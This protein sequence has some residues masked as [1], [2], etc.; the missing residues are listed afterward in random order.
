MSS[1][2]SIITQIN[3]LIMK[4]NAKTGRRDSDLTTSYEALLSGYSVDGTFEPVKPFAFTINAKSSANS[5]STFTKY[6]HANCNGLDVSNYSMATIS[7][8]S[9][10]ANYYQ[11][12]VNGITMIN[13]STIDLIGVDTLNIGIYGTNSSVGAST[14]Y[15]TYKIILTP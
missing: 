5:E 15:V 14:L 2:S 10:N 13:P 3:R 9:T 6:A 4:G 11:I 1:L 7:L 12:T 8:E